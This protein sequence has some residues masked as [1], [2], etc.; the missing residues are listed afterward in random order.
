MKNFRL[1]STSQVLHPEHYQY[2][3]KKKKKRNRKWQT[4]EKTSE[5]RAGLLVIKST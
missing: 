2:H 3:H 1:P 4:I 5:I